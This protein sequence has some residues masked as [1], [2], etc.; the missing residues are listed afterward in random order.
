VSKRPDPTP[1]T[2]RMCTN[3][4]AEVPATVWAHLPD[5]ERYAKLIGM[6][7]DSGAVPATIGGRP[8]TLNARLIAWV[9]REDLTGK[10]A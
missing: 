4:V 5:A 9:E 1:I 3:D 8:V 6:M 7:T 10:S 2:V